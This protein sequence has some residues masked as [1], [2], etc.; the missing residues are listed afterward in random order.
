M[1][2]NIIHVVILRRNIGGLNILSQNIPNYILSI[3]V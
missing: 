1:V 2:N 3:P